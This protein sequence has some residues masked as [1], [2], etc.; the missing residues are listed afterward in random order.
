MTP[1]A[2]INDDVLLDRL[3]DVFRREGFEGASLSRIAEATGLKRASLYHRFPEG[4][5]QMA[6]AVLKRVGER[7]ADDVL[8]PLGEDAP[9][10]SRIRK[11]G[12]RLKRFYENGA[13]PC[14]LEALSLGQTPALYDTLLADALQAWIDAFAR[15][16]KESGLRAPAAQRNAEDA[17]ARIQGALILARASGNAGAFERAV[18]ELETMLTADRV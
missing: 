1:P 8:A 18:N 4:K 11:T 6:A 2:R 12:A 3:T 17:V 16:A 7:F 15:V 10:A 9:I 13:A 14:L 5:D